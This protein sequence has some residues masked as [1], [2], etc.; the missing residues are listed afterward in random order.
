MLRTFMD[1]AEPLGDSAHKAMLRKYTEYMI[2]GGMPQVVSA[3]LEHHNMMDAEFVKRDIL[4]LYRNDIHK[5][6]GASMERALALFN[7]IPAL[8]SSPHKVLSPTKIKKGSRKREYDGAVEWLCDAM[9]LNRCRCSSDPS[10]VIGLSE[11]IGRVKC[12]FL[13]TG[14]LISLA[15][16]NDK[17]GLAE[18]Y[19]LLMDGK[20]SVN[21]GMLFENMVA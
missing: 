15:F 5:I 18:T 7:S 9:I 19:G 13:D 12:Y 14:L 21:K 8:L 11:D 17:A 4:D 16:Q 10:M 2:I 6:Q 3:Y 20:L 1:N